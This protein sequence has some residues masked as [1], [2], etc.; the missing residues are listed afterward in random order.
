MH[1]YPLTNR[2]LNIHLFYLWIFYLWISTYTCFFAIPNLGDGLSATYS[3]LF[4]FNIITRENLSYHIKF[5]LLSLHIFIMAK[6]SLKIWLKKSER[7]KSLVQWKSP[8]RMK[9]S[10]VHFKSLV[11]IFY[12]FK[13]KIKFNISD[14]W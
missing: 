9:K 7:K 13:K 10:V 1:M 5:D 14:F 3:P 2:Y 12:P 11:C 4:N 6:I 8:L